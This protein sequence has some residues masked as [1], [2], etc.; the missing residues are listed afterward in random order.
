MTIM[1]I[2]DAALV[3]K[4]LFPLKGPLVINDTIS[5]NGVL[6]TSVNHDA[7]GFYA[8]GLSVTGREVQVRLDAH[9]DVFTLE[10]FADRPGA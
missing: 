1:K 5:V 9:G 7:V 4:R 8:L 6:I 3:G 2:L 10:P